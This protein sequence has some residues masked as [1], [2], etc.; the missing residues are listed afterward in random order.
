MEIEELERRLRRLERRVKK[1][2]NLLEAGVPQT[3]A[4]PIFEYGGAK[5]YETGDPYNPYMVVSPEG[6]SHLYWKRSYAIEVAKK[7]GKSSG[8]EGG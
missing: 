5:V 7:L 4:E 3:R 2:E 6:E 8:E 1:I